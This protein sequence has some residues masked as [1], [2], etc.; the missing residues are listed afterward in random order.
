MKLTNCKTKTDA[1]AVFERIHQKRG[2]QYRVV[3]TNLCLQKLGRRG[4][5]IALK[6]CKKNNAWQHF[7]G[8]RGAESFDIRVRKQKGRCLTNHHHPKEDEVV[9]AESC[10]KAHKTK[11]GY[12]SEY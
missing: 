7:T 4:T 6:P 11:T 5:N 3:G 9:Y 8:F 10:F 1:D 12:W 2:D